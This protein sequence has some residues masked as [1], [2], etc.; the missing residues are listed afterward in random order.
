MPEKEWYREWFNSPF[1]HKLYFE[2]DEKEAEDFIR[3]LTQRLQIP[4]GSRVLDVACGRGRHARILATF[5][6]DVTA[7][8]L[9]PGNIAF[10][11][12]FESDNLHFFVHDMRL[13][14]WG[15]FFDYAFN[16]YTSFG[17]FRTRREHE[18]AIRA[19]SRSLKPGGRFIIDYLNVHYTEDHLRPEETKQ[20]NGTV[21]DIK[22]WQTQTHFYKNVKIS[23]AS[24]SKP[25]EHTEIVAK[26]SPG[27]FT[28]MFSY[29]DLQIE[30]VFG[31][32][33]LDPYD[34]KKTP[35]LIIIARKN[36]PATKDK[37]KRLYSDGRKTDLLT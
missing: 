5:G 32:Y 28:D 33:N 11:Q 34:V 31:N 24:L 35:R 13:P 30:E 4:H 9:A 18:A 37:E 22:R 6:F 14:F 23:D 16:F 12:K 2:H 3:R 26:L 17:Y 15:N 7:T 10:A 29:Q 8:D 27:D 1:Y 21:Y 36:S 25:N 20:L 19:I